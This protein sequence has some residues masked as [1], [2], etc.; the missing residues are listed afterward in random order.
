MAFE[1]IVMTMLILFADKWNFQHP[2]FLSVEQE[3]NSSANVADILL[4]PG[5]PID[6]VGLVHP[7]VLR[8]DLVHCQEVPL[9]NDL[10]LVGD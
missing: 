2:I 6:S 5:M 8:V 1:M 10:M 3:E 7:R 4:N 9:S